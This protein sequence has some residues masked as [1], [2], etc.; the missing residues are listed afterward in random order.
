MK[1]IMPVM[2]LMT[3]S[4]VMKITNPAGL[5]ERC[6]VSTT[7]KIGGSRC[8]SLSEAMGPNIGRHGQEVT[9]E[10]DPSAPEKGARRQ[11]CQ[12]QGAEETGGRRQKGR[13]QGA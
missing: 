9:F 1:K 3:P 2:K 13:S 7:E 11:S 5:S 8:G 4:T 10:Q 12:G 6:G